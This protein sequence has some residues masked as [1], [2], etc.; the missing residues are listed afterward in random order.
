MFL[1]FFRH[2]PLLR[3]K[4]AAGK[5]PT[6]SFECDYPLPRPPRALRETYTLTRVDSGPFHLFKRNQFSPS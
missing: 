1:L 2:S 4:K 3:K 5:E 6:L